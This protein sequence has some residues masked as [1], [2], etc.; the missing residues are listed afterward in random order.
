MRVVFPFM[1]QE[2]IGIESLSAM[3]QTH[4]HETYLAFD[5][6]L[7]ND[8][9]H[10]HY[11]NLSKLFSVKKRLIREIIEV[12]PDLVGFSV[13]TNELSWALEVASAI[14]NE[15]DVP[16]I[17][18]GIHPTSAP[19]TTIAYDV[20]D[21]ICIGEG[22][23]ALVELLEKIE[24]GLPTDNIQNIWKKTKD[25]TI[26]KNPIRK[27]TDADLDRLPTPD[28]TIFEPFHD[29]RSSYRIMTARGCPY[30]C[31][32]CSSPLQMQQYKAVNTKSI[33]FRSL[34]L[35]MK[36]LVDAKSRYK[37][38]FFDIFDDVFTAKESRVI[39]FCKRYKEEVGV[40]FAI[41]THPSMLNENMVIALKEAGCT[42][43]Q[44]GIQSMDER[45]RKDI[46]KRPVTDKTILRVI[47]LC[48]KHGL[49]FELD[50][51]FG[52]PTEPLSAQDKAFQ[53]YIDWQPLRINTF[54]LTLYPG[55]GMV[56]TM[57]QYGLISEDY[58]KAVYHGKSVS[59]D[60]HD[61]GV[62]TQKEMIKA[63]Q[64]YEFLFRL[65]SVLPRRLVQFIYRSKGYKYLYLFKSLIMWFDIVG[66]IQYRSPKHKEYVLYY[67]R[68][69]IRFLKKENNVIKS[70]FFERP[71]N[72]EEFNSVQTTRSMES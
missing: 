69:L 13:F 32:Y 44:T 16:I 59:K 1:G 19:D 24:N 5:A 63:F 47:N 7:F 27:I 48:K 53:Y 26:I 36:E 62:I 29:L 41:L 3:L 68:N 38:N 14:K 6:S 15:L 23:F 70:R 42:G 57:S 25:R 20:V 49:S 61:G 60:Y 54:W 31:T 34:D 71:V 17:F 43:V 21:Y 35:V 37:S 46:L 2:N 8:Q 66:A 50:H 18:G 58:A 11:K 39:E 55:I 4:G 9:F 12:A 56:S 30:L 40:P 22:E 45:V 67:I 52:I 72:V 10:F 51:I 33:R 65:I 28:K 64:N